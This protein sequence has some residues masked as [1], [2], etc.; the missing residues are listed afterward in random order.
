[1][2]YLIDRFSDW[3]IIKKLFL[4]IDVVVYSSV[5]TCG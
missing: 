2:K 1:M 5:E 4:I 3:S